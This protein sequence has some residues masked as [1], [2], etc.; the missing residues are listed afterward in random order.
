MEE[1]KI[2]VKQ[3]VDLAPMIPKKI[4]DLSKLDRINFVSNVKDALREGTLEP[5]RV[6]IFVKQ[7]E[8][9]AKAF[10]E[11][12]EYKDMVLVEAQKYGKGNHT[13]ENS[14]FFTKEAGV[15]YNY[16]ACG[17]PEWVELKAKLADRE[18]FLKSLPKE[19]IDIICD[20]GDVRK[21][22]PPIKNSTT[23]IQTTLL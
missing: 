15:T 10:T 13:F 17:D 20:G 4:L 5:L 8:T 19:G 3:K 9:I 16:L 7:L 12:K 14:K 11:D 2:E 6:N 23:I 21:I 1:N 18:T 22:Y